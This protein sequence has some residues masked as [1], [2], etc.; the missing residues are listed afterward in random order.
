MNVKC[1]CEGI[2]FTHSFPKKVKEFNSGDEKENKFLKSILSY[3]V[4]TGRL[5]LKKVHFFSFF[6]F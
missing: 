5:L 6:F 3:S 1:A 4:P 2:V